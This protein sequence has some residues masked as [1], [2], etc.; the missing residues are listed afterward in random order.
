MDEDERAIIEEERRRAMSKDIR[1]AMCP[2]CER[3]SGGALMHL[4]CHYCG[5]AW[6]AEGA[7]QPKV[8]PW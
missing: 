3:W 5:H 6:T 8:T 4:S 1:E 2:R 7:A